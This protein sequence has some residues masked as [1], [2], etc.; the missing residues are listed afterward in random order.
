MR[1]LRVTLLLFLASCAGEP[2]DLFFYYGTVQN[3]AGQALAQRSV[4]LNRTT[5]DACYPS[6]RDPAWFPGQMVYEPYATFVTTE[7]GEFLL[8]VMRYQVQTSGLTGNGRCFQAFVDGEGSAARTEALFYGVAQDQEFP[9]MLVWEDAQLQTQASASGWTLTRPE[10]PLPVKNPPGEQMPSAGGPSDFDRRYYQ[11]RLASAGERFWVTR[12]D[13]V[14]ITL[15]A[16]VLEDFPTPTAGLELLSES[17]VQ[18]SL[19]GG[20]GILVQRSRTEAQA[21]TRPGLIPV[22]RGAACT[23]NGS[24]DPGCRATDGSP[25]LVNLQAVIYDE[26]G[27]PGPTF[28]GVIAEL[29]LSR[30][31]VARTLVLRDVTIGAG[32]VPQDGLVLRVEGSADGVTYRNLGE[33]ALEPDPM[34]YRDAEGNGL[35][36]MIPLDTTGAPVTRVRLW[37]GTPTVISALREISVFE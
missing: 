22:S 17:Q 8:E 27:S 2:D 36:E 19:L 15:P 30:P 23:L 33:L 1:A 11:W 24:T 37:S 13:P 3:G 29:V 21:L 6:L 35:H 34:L 5:G 10:L 25:T 26:R 7:E 31:V 18:G 4:A 28:T 16:E 32:A 20:G 14:A 12:A 9:P